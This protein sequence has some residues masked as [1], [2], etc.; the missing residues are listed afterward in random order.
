MQMLVAVPTGTGPRA[1]SGDMTTVKQVGAAFGPSQRF[2]ADLSDPD[3]TT[4]NLV[5]GQSGDPASPWYMD[6]FPDWLNGRTYP[7]PFSAAATQAATMHTLI[8]NPR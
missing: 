4:L 1:E 2:T 6:Q 7:M 8:L 5:L 3:R